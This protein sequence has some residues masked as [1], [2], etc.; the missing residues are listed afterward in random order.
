MLIINAVL[1]WLS[2]LF[3]PGFR[4]RGFFAALVGSLVLTLLTSALRYVVF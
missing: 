4:V 2:S 3:T 1:L